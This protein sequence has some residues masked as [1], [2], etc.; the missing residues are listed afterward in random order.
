MVGQACLGR[1]SVD[2]RHSSSSYVTPHLV[3]LMVSPSLTTG[4]AMQCLSST[5]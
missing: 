5:C 4:A 3:T 2:S 1:L